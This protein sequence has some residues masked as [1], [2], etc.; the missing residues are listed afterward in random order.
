M[1]IWFE[2]T[3]YASDRD[4][5]YYQGVP[6]TTLKGWE[7]NGWT[8]FVKDFGDDGD[9]KAD[10]YDEYEEDV[11]KY[12][13]YNALNGVQ[14]PLYA[15]YSSNSVASEFWLPPTFYGYREMLSRQGGG[16]WSVPASTTVNSEYW[17]GN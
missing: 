13:Y 10:E 5:K 4:Y 15:D 11:N 8:W 9:E 12:L 2:Q 6:S 1:E 16:S 14:M 7:F 3:Y 17:Y